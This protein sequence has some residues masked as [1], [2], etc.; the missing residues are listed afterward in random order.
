MPNEADGDTEEKP[1]EEIG[2][3]AE[4]LRGRNVPRQ[5]KAVEVEDHYRNGHNLYR[6]WCEH[7]RAARMIAGK[8]VHN[9][10]EDDPQGPP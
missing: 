7:C 3:E 8:H 9:P 2:E 5:P 10:D 4:C 6:A 1:T